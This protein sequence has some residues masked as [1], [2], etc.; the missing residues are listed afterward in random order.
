MKGFG[1]FRILSADHKQQKTQYGERVTSALRQ[2]IHPPGRHFLLIDDPRIYFGNRVTKADSS[3]NHA[4]F[5]FGDFGRVRKPL[6]GCFGPENVVCDHKSQ[7]CRTWSAVKRRS[8]FIP[9]LSL[10][11]GPLP[12]KLILPVA[13]YPCRRNNRRRWY[14]IKRSL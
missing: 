7:K 14:S 4:F 13:S 2:L 3:W 6:D 12:V 1:W 11:R 9:S 5:H 8:N 10:P